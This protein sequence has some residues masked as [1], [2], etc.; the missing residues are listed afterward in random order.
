MNII[1]RGCAQNK[2]FPVLLE[3]SARVVDMAAAP[4]A[5]ASRMIANAA[6]LTLLRQNA[7]GVLRRTDVAFCCD[8]MRAL[9]SVGVLLPSSDKYPS[10]SYYGGQHCLGGQ[11]ILNVSIETDPDPRERKR[12]RV[13][14]MRV[15]PTVADYFLSLQPIRDELLGIPNAADRAKGFA[16]LRHGI[17]SAL[18]FDVLHIS[19]SVCFV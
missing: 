5:T 2:Y 3:Q 15:F 12:F 10:C 9:C 7:S 17:Y 6:L 18:A 14:E 8:Q 13:D 1:P 11:C 16:E 19:G 4:P